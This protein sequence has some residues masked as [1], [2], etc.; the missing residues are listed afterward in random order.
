MLI[1]NFAIFSPLEHELKVS[2]EVFEQFSHYSACEGSSCV[3]YAFHYAIS[4]FM[5]EQIEGKLKEL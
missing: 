1:I 4:L 5:R 3:Y 2:R